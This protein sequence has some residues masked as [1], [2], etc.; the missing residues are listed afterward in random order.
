MAQ[1][2]QKGRY[3]GG[4]FALHCYKG[5]NRRYIFG[6]RSFL[7]VRDGHRDLL[8]FMQRFTAITVNRAEVYEYILA[9]FALNES[10]SFFIIEP[11][12]CTFD[13]I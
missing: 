13:L 4:L 6:L 7:S 11:L 2:Q 12:D 5:L 1:V 3:E 10:P 9:S 8:S